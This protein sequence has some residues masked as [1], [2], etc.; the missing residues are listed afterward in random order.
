M[1]E[2]SQPAA[3]AQRSASA[4]NCNAPGAGRETLPAGS[5]IAYGKPAAVSDCRSGGMSF[6]VLGKGHAG[7]LGKLVQRGGADKPGCGSQST[8][9]CFCACADD[10]NSV[11]LDAGIALQRFGNGPKVEDLQ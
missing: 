2:C 7:G 1:H 11:W 3:G 10:R 8:W 9:F 4:G 5:A 6:C